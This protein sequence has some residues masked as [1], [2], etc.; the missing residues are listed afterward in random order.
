ME[1]D[2]DAGAAEGNGV[3]FSRWRRCSVVLLPLSSVLGVG[4]LEPDP[5]FQVADAM[6]GSS[7]ASAHGI[8]SGGVVPGDGDGDGDG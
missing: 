4:C 2:T 7:T 5:A 6:P 3:G 1:A 8:T